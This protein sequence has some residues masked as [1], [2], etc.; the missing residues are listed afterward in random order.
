MIFFSLT[1]EWIRIIEIRSN[2]QKSTSKIA[3]MRTL[4]RAKMYSNHALI[5][6]YRHRGSK[7]RSKKIRSEISPRN[8]THNNLINFLRKF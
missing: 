5:N 2:I 1:T 6:D 3:I 4:I 7:L 8:V